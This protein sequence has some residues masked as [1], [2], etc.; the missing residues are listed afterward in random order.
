VQ[1][2]ATATVVAPASLRNEAGAPAGA[3]PFLQDEANSAK[4]SVNGMSCEG[5]GTSRFVMTGANVREGE[6]DHQGGLGGRAGT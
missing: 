4:M 2:E 3:Q 6:T 5:E 1:N